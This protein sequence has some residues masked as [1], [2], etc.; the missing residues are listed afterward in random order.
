M[1]NKCE[2]FTGYHSY[3]IPTMFY[4]HNNNNNNTYHYILVYYNIFRIPMDNRYDFLIKSFCHPICNNLLL[5]THDIFELNF[6]AS[7]CTI[8]VLDICMLSL[9]QYNISIAKKRYVTNRDSEY[10]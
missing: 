7:H 9:L 6:S 8:H 1:K 10:G 5:F 3:T 2:L 4:N